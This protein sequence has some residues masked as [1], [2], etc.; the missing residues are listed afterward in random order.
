MIF[1]DLHDI[2]NRFTFKNLENFRRFQ[3][4]KHEFPDGM[5][6][7]GLVPG[8]YRRPFL[9]LFGFT[10]KASSHISFWGNG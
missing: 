1:L 10:L 6:T 9:H 7:L 2:L 4:Q 5:S 8:D 3:Q